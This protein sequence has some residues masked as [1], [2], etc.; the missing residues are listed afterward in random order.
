MLLNRKWWSDKHPHANDWSREAH[1]K[2]NKFDEITKV[3]DCHC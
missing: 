1:R 3:N 2:I